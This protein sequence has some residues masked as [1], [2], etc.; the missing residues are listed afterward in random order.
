MMQKYKFYITK[1]TTP[2]KI[3]AIYKKLTLNPFYPIK[4]DLYPKRS[5]FKLI[6]FKMRLFNI[7]DF[8]E[9]LTVQVLFA[10]FGF[11]KF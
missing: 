1:N 7:H 5:S 10:L 9:F 11:L 4:K 6:E 3:G 8:K 2:K